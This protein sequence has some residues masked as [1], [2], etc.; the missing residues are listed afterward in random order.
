MDANDH[1][2]DVA[3]VDDYDDDELNCGSFVCQLSWRSVSLQEDIR[4]EVFFNTGIFSFS[5]QLTAKKWR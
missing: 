1:G 3:V 4:D 5:H 2:D